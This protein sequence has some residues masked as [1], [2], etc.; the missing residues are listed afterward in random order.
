MTIVQA[1][2]R[3]H[4][5]SEKNNF[6]GRLRQIVDIKF[7][8]EHLMNSA[9]SRKLKND[10]HD[11]SGLDSRRVPVNSSFFRRRLIETDGKAA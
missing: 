5:L 10:D 6:P 8:R 9:R 11:Y 7:V 1:S 4:V 3:K 2:C